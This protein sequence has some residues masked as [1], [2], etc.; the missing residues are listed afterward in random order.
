MQRQRVS[1]QQKPALVQAASAVASLEARRLQHKAARLLPDL[2]SLPPDGLED[3]ASAAADLLSL[4]NSRDFSS[5][6]TD[7]VH[8]RTMDALRQWYPK[9]SD[10]RLLPEQLLNVAR[11]AHSA[12]TSISEATTSQPTGEGLLLQL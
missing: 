1:Q 3:A 7:E 9:S 12:D 5:T 10:I 6:A 11:S 2:I 4:S 8:A